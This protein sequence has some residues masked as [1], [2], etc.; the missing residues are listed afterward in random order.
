MYFICRHICW[1]L[2]VWYYALHL[3][4][5]AVYSEYPRI[6]FCT[7]YK[8]MVEN[9]DRYFKILKNTKYTKAKLAQRS[10]NGFYCLPFTT[11]KTL[12]KTQEAKK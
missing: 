1:E 4:S 2:I 8:M 11:G 10:D 5:G 3:K 7:V 9:K 12:K 6:T